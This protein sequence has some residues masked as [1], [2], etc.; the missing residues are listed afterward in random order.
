MTCAGSRSRQ[1]TGWNRRRRSGPAARDPAPPPSCAG[2]A[3]TGAAAAVSESAGADGT[4]RSSTRAISAATRLPAPTTTRANPTRRCRAAR[5]AAP[6]WSRAACRRPTGPS[7]GSCA[8]APRDAA[9]D[10]APAAR[11]AG[12]RSLRPPAAPS[13]S[14]CP[15][16]GPPSALAAAST[17]RPMTMLRRSPRPSASAPK[18]TPQLIPATCT[19]DSRKPA[20]QQRHGPGPRAA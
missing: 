7:S 9:P 19:S 5:A 15:A 6:G 8:A 12:S 3:A 10:R 14:R 11:R 17:S 13:A 4:Q 20:W 16:R 2:A 1:A 18:A